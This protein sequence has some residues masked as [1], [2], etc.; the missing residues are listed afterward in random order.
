MKR[1]YFLLAIA[2]TGLCFNA[3]A[4][5]Y[6]GKRYRDPF[7]SL[8]PGKVSKEKTGEVASAPKLLL[9]GLLWNAVPPRAIL[10]GEVVEAGDILQGVEVL[11]ISK[12]GVTVRQSGVEFFLSRRGGAK[13][14]TVS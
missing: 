4:A 3:D 8:M 1:V 14:E 13:H 6:E 12:E 5:P 2:I 9:E 10:S 11:R 7:K